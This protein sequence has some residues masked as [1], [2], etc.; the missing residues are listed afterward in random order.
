MKQVRYSKQAAKM[1]KAM[2]PDITLRIVNTIDTFARGKSVD[3]KKMTGTTY[4]R[5][6]VGKWRIII[7]EVDIVVLIVKIGSRGDIYKGR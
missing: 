7:D 2:Q 5:I 4:S 6:R 1:L 3:I